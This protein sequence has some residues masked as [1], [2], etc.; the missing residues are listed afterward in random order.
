[1]GVCLE[2]KIL[3]SSLT[4]AAKALIGDAPDETSI[5]EARV[6]L[7]LFLLVSFRENWKQ[8]IAPRNSSRAA[9][10]IHT[11]ASLFLES[12]HTIT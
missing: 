4:I 6:R 10:S 12:P 5:S 11:L 3:D 8:I 2:F 1:M 9:F 7:F